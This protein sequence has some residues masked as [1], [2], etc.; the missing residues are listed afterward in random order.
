MVDKS[1]SDQDLYPTDSLHLSQESQCTQES[2][3]GL[4]G[5]PMASQEVDCG[6]SPAKEEK[7]K[8]KK[9]KDK[10]KDKEGKDGK[11]EKK[12]KKSSRHKDGD[13][14]EHKSKRSSSRRPEPEGGNST[15]IVHMDEYDKVIYNNDPLFSDLELSDKEGGSE[16]QQTAPNRLR[17]QPRLMGAPGSGIFI[18]CPQFGINSNTMIKFAI[19][20]TELQNVLQ[21][22]LKRVGCKMHLLIIF[23]SPPPLILHG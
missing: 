10:D 16:Q 19:I 13:E 11:K 6:L 12:K 22:S 17:R 15:S 14:K 21:V 18:P 23:S 5:S 2:D 1:P 20:G 9:K 7:K 3:G 4:T 8:K